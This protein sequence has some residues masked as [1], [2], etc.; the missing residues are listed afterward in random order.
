[1]ANADKGS[2]GS[3]AAGGGGTN[4]KYK[5]IHALSMDAP[6]ILYDG[7]PSH[8][9]E[10]ANHPAHRVGGYFKLSARSAAVFPR[11]GELTVPG[12]T[13]VY[14]AIITRY[15]KQNQPTVMPAAM[16][17]RVVIDADVR[18][19]PSVVLPPV[20]GSGSGEDDDDDCY[21]RL[22]GYLSTAYDSNKSR[23]GPR[24]QIK[25]CADLRI[26]CCSKVVVEQLAKAP[27]F[28]Q[29]L[30]RF[31]AAVGNTA[32][33]TPTGCI[34]V[35][36]YNP[37]TDESDLT[38]PLSSTPVDRLCWIAA[39][40]PAIPYLFL[41]RMVIDFNRVQR[42]EL[43]TGVFV[44]AFPLVIDSALNRAF[45]DCPLQIDDDDDGGAAAAGN[46][47]NANEVV[48]ES[49]TDAVAAVDHPRFVRAFDETFAD[50][51]YQQ[52]CVAA[53]NCGFRNVEQALVVDGLHSPYA[54]NHVDGYVVALPLSAANVRL[55][56]YAQ[57]YREE[58]AA[59][60][61]PWTVYRD[62]VNLTTNTGATMARYTEYQKLDKPRQWQKHYAEVCEMIAGLVARPSVGQVVGFAV[63][64]TARGGVGS[65]NQ[66]SL[67]TSS[68]SGET[69]TSLS[70][71]VYGV[72]H[73]ADA[74]LNLCY[75]FAYCPSY[76]YAAV[77][78]LIKCEH[79][80][81]V[82][83]TRSAVNEHSSTNCA[84]CRNEAPVDAPTKTKLCLPAHVAAYYATWRPSA[85]LLVSPSSSVPRNKSLPGVC[86]PVKG[87][88]PAMVKEAW[89]FKL[90]ES[91][92]KLNEWVKRKIPFEDY[93][94]AQLVVKALNTNAFK[95]LESTRDELLASIESGRQRWNA[96]MDFPTAAEE[97]NNDRTDDV[98]TAINKDYDNDDPNVVAHQ[99]AS[100]CGETF[101]QLE[102]AFTSFVARVKEI[103]GDSAGGAAAE[104]LAIPCYTRLSSHWVAAD[105]LSP[106]LYTMSCASL[107]RQ[108]VAMTTRGVTPPTT[109]GQQTTAQTGVLHGTYV[110]LMAVDMASN[111]SF[112]LFRPAVEPADNWVAVT[113]CFE[114]H[115][116]QLVMPLV[117]ATLARRSIVKLPMRIDLI[118]SPPSNTNYNQGSGAGQNTDVARVIA[119]IRAA[120]TAS[121]AI[122][123][124]DAKTR[125]MQLAKKT[126]LGNTTVDNTG[127]P[128]PRRYLC[129]KNNA[130]ADV[131]W[132]L[133]V[134]RC[135]A[136]QLKAESAFASALPRVLR[137]LLRVAWTLRQ[138]RLDV[139]DAWKYVTRGSGIA[140]SIF[141]GGGCK[142]NDHAIDSGD[143]CGVWSRFYTI[144]V[145]S[146]AR[147][148][149]KQYFV[150]V[151]AAH[152]WSPTIRKSKFTELVAFC[153]DV[154]IDSGNFGER[155]FLP[156]ANRFS[157]TRRIE[158]IDF[159]LD[160]R[161]LS[162]CVVMYA[163]T[164][165]FIR[166]FGKTTRVAMALNR[167]ERTTT[168]TGWD[169]IDTGTRAVVSSRY[170]LT[171]IACE[172]GLVPA[173]R[174]SGLGNSNEPEVDLCTDASV[175]TMSDSEQRALA[176]LCRFSFGTD[177]C[178]DPNDA[179]YH[180]D[181][182]KTVRDI[183]ARNCPNNGPLVR[184]FLRHLVEVVGEGNGGEDWKRGLSHPLD[185]YYH[186]VI[187]M[188]ESE[189][190]AQ[191]EQKDDEEEEEEDK[192]TVDDSYD[193]SG[194]VT[195][196]AKE[197]NRTR[198]D[199]CDDNED[200][201]DN[202]QSVYKRT[203][204]SL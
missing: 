146:L 91:D 126:L 29:A 163:Q 141:G 78:A 182:P 194:F 35:A 102:Q 121:A 129:C 124:D 166:K 93:G 130:N 196:T 10:Y 88:T 107:I 145:D 53:K 19:F 133:F 27:T 8:L 164:M 186:N 177:A 5:E 34:R 110:D 149:L 111:G 94:G 26:A 100:V 123:G 18:I 156:T 3:A 13:P 43:R 171:H 79:N 11:V 76:V 95:A 99:L 155:L 80:N 103:G 198:F 179:R 55:T 48:G 116:P 32:V 108:C 128:P 68:S 12:D 16:S 174:G 181:N 39:R 148:A 137:D 143:L 138:T 42:I 134:L 140:A 135:R 38:T 82:D 192:A 150:R 72:A 56:D 69:D 49:L 41:G 58:L 151:D 98:S 202:G 50:E 64:D 33:C 67:A 191:K 136:S 152:T 89:S 139:Y 46:E 187:A 73:F 104:K 165:T 119:S 15:D 101:D 125:Y 47:E 161:N 30:D 25:S 1:M 157:V 2:G 122:A 96:V 172:R 118:L 159:L 105:I 195:K 106:T 23:Y 176:K 51:F 74:F 31:Y 127:I 90:F 54:P 71:L 204:F 40:E 197:N 154:G 185:Q 87:V 189:G 180:I 28:R 97:D 17:P 14:T 201:D 77:A 142:P 112:P 61:V 120:L 193:W 70:S 200:S 199:I 85:A 113:G 167:A 37:D 63:V 20:L 84:Y 57:A 184:L 60:T 45:L 168:T 36:R 162:Q 92:V 131:A 52:Y 62:C 86:A 169:F 21:D 114:T 9:V 7:D 183:A 160:R 188:K 178:A 147:T 144:L 75:T 66:S 81:N 117:S 65:E 83:A 190:E 109:V 6:A 22:L 153:A 132:C 44:F 59:G 203:K 173:L 4:S 115:A 170:Y 24:W 158:T 175:V